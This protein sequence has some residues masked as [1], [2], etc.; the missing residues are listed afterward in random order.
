MWFVG[1]LELQRG[2]VGVKEN[3]YNNGK[4]TK[5]YWW[6]YQQNADINETAIRRSW[7]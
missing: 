6:E 7:Y 1:C 2:Q 4:R 3:K 5:V